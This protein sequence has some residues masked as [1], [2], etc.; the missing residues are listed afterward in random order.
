MPLDERRV[1]ETSAWIRKALSDLLAARVDLDAG[2]P[3]VEDA[4]FHCQQ[5]AEKALKGFL[6]WHDTPFR[7]V[8]DL[9]ELGRQC[10]GIDPSLELVCREAE[11]LTIFATVFR[12]PG[13]AGEPSAHEAEN[14]LMTARRLCDAV[15]S[16]LPIDVA[17]RGMK[18]AG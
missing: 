16:R 15:T 1:E 9:T 14:A 18:G 5:A 11:P 17:Q 4:L 12:Y 7:K 2:T 6:A 8:H 13:D 10:I 3:L